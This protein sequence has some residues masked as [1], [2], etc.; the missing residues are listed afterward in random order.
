MNL[1][2]IIMLRLV[3]LG[4]HTLSEAI[5]FHFFFLPAACANHICQYFS[6]L[7]DFRFFVLQRRRIALMGAKFGVKNSTFY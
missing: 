4:L 7:G 1:F 5:K 6:Y 3:E 2:Y